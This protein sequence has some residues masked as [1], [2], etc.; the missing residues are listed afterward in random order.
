MNIRP[1]VFHYGIKFREDGR[2]EIFP[3]AEVSLLSKRGNGIRAVLYIDSGATTSILPTGDAEVLNIDLSRGHRMAV[4]AA[5]GETVYGYRHEVVVQF[6][7]TKLKIPVIFIEHDAAP[8][9]LGR[10]G[11]FTKFAVLFDE[12]RRRTVLLNPKTTRNEIN[13]LF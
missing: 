2:I 10:E 7:K 3:A 4:K 11:I 5:F 12:T 8:R 13:N 1:I 6:E 9:I